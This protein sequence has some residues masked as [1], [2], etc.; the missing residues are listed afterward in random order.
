MVSKE[1]KNVCDNKAKYFHAIKIMILRTFTSNDQ[2]IYLSQ[3]FVVLGYVI[4][5]ISELI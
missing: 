5:S 3:H 4:K 1:E 2:K